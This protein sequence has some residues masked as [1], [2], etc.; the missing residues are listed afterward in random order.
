MID[1]NT[2]FKL[3]ILLCRSVCPLVSRLA[4]VPIVR[5]SYSRVVFDV[6]IFPLRPVK[7]DMQQFLHVIFPTEEVLILFIIFPIE[8]VDFISY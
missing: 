8:E 3:F 4:L 1:V 5:S 7:F 2:L 6:F